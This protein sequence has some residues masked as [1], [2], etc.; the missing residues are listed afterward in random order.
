M[1]L[2]VFVAVGLVLYSCDSSG[3][4][5][6]QAVAPST[7]TQ[8]VELSESEK[9]I[10]PKS[11]V[12]EKKE[13]PN[14]V[15]I[16][17]FERGEGTT[18]QDGHVYEIN[19]KVKLTNGT[20]IDGNHKLQRDMLPFLVGYQ[21]QTK[22]FDI[23]LHELKIGDFVEI[24]IPGNLARG[25]KGIPGLVPPN[26]PNI[27]LLR[28]GKEIIPTKTIA[29]VKVWRLEEN[30]EVKDAAITND[31]EISLHYFVGTQTNPRYDNSYQRNQTFDIGLK[32]AALLPGL[33]KALVGMK[34]YDKLW[35][36][37]PAEQAYGK[38]GMLDLVK[39]NESIFYDV[40]VM[41]VDHKNKMK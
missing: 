32:D 8:G 13:F 12:L 16:Q 40:I 31:S 20:V 19:F 36:L 9:L 21:M 1:R 25:A 2:F 14:G 7:K 6:N 24:Y 35:I 18:L 30:K 38:D 5:V 28:I 3:V 29:G 27:V 39:P 26:A 17:W 15:K 11:T 34:M 37:V 10:E 22:G 33:R 41:D 23:A 4:E